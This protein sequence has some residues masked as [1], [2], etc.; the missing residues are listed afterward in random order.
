VTQASERM[1][2]R[3]L[4]R[5]GLS[6][7]V[8][9]VGCSPFGN[10]RRVE[11]ETIASDVITAALEIDAGFFDVA[12]YYGFGLAERR[13][14]DALR[15]IAADFILSTK[16]GRLLLPDPEI[17]TSVARNGFYSP[18]KFRPHFDYSY[19]GMMRSHENSLHRLG[20]AKI[21]LLLVHDLGTFAHGSNSESRLQQFRDGGLRALEELRSSGTISAYG[22][23]VNEPEI[24]ETLVSEGSFD[25]F[26][27]AS[28]Y[29]LLNHDACGPLFQKCQEHG[30]SIIAAGPYNS[31]LLAPGSGSRSDAL[32]NY[33]PATKQILEKLA[34]LERIC[35]DFEVP[36]AGAALQFPLR[37]PIVSSVVPGLGNRQRVLETRELL[38]LP[39]PDAFWS[40]LKDSGHLV[41]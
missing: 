20:L 11:S 15:S 7:P 26:M 1:P 4:G 36:L 16:V 39:I 10:R 33:Q 9:G 40:T 17:D 37:S 28:C 29:T 21:D 35:R 32:F 3:P 2:R 5:S 24:C 18:L 25:C 34:E 8:L 13:A 6:L 23:G 12:P 38:D 27:L 19:D 41:A 14:G 30:V 22:L 31:G